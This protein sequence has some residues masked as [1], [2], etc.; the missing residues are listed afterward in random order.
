M[1]DFD[2]ALDET[3]ARATAEIAKTDALVA[4]VVSARE[5]FAAKSAEWGVTGEKLGRFFDQLSP[6]AREEVEKEDSAF[7]GGLAEMLDSAATDAA[8]APSSRPKG[9]RNYV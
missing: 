1:T 8:G 2:K 4:E 9:G 7:F 5:V 3:I 6:E